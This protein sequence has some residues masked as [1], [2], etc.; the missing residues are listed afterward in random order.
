MTSTLHVLI[1]EIRKED[2]RIKI[3]NEKGKIVIV[4]AASEKRSSKQLEND[5]NI[6]DIININ[7]SF[8]KDLKYLGSLS[9]S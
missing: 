5:V 7:L 3:K 8:K 2:K 1:R 4:L 9:L 6:S